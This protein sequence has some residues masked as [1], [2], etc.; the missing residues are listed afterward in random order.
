M[1]HLRS[2]LFFLLCLAPAMAQK[3]LTTYPNCTFEKTPWADGDS[4]LVKP[5][6]QEAFS[7]R[8]YGVDCIE[9]H[10]TDT[11]DARR[12]RAQRSYFGI[13][14]VDPDPQKA[15]EMAKALG[16]KAAQFVAAALQKPF[17]VHTALADAR[18][19]A[20]FTRVYAF[21]VTAD[22]KDLG[23]E[24]VKQGHARAFGVN[25]ETYHQPALSA[26]EYET[27]LDDFELQAATNKSGVWA[28]TN[29]ALLPAERK[30]QRDDD[31][32][33]L[34]GIDNAKDLNGKKINPNTATR[35]ELMKLPRVGEATANRI[36]ENRPFANAEDLHKVPGIGPKTL[37]DLKPHLEFK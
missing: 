35:D 12:L 4:F 5:P 27:M 20:N 37:K 7:I 36:I 15:A 9:W 33:D 32:K 30:A 21:I 2:I 29:M 22:G 19:D 26:D 28:H 14:K 23:E 13:S 16:E 10:V 1:N 6:G 17:T 25:R 24:L 18:G 34:I 31:A 8:L 3:P 11:T